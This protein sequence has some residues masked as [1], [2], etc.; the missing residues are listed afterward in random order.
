MTDDL[1]DLRRALQ[2]APPTD[3]AAKARALA[4]AMENFDR[5]QGSA[6]PARSSKDRPPRAAP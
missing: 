3:D 1:D 5:L 4:L 6:D 2:A